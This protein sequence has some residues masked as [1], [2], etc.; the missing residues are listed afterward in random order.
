MLFIQYYVLIHETK[1]L[2]GLSMFKQIYI[3]HEVQNETISKLDITLMYNMKQ[4]MTGLEDNR[5]IYLPREIQG[6]LHPQLITIANS[7]HV[8][9]IYSL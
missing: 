2:C 7:K 3:K 5:Q 9:V 6:R 1:N 4:I 8:H